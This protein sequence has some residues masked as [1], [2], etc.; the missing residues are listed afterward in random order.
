MDQTNR[1]SEACTPSGAKPGSVTITRHDLQI[2]VVL[3]L[4]CLLVYNAN[5]RS[6]SAA[7]TFGARYLPFGIWRYHTVL[8]DPIL[9]VAAQGRPIPQKPD[10]ANVAFWIVRARG[11]HTVSLY[12][13]TA[14][15][16][17]APLYLPAVVYL[18]AKGWDQLNLD[19]VA[20][21]MEK[22]IS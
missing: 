12:P 22:L 10:Q 4:L 16:I 11:G 18:N 20:W 8:L 3:A 19:R 1:D 17:V 5:L 6:I 13:I 2:S 9:T 14:P 15:V 7:D 21:M